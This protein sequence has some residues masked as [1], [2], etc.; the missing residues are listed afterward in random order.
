[1]FGT[2]QP[3]IAVISLLEV[4]NVFFPAHFAN[5]TCCPR[6]T[7]HVIIMATVFGE[8]YEE[9]LSKLFDISC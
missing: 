2:F 9:L 3:A 8:H 6:A 7:V 1:M 5:A 4:P